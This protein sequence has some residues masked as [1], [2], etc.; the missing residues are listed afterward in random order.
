[1]TIE[2]FIQSHSKEENAFV[3]YKGKDYKI[4][5]LECQFYQK[6]KIGI[7][8]CYSMFETQ[9]RKEFHDWME[10]KI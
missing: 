1:M 7:F 10:S 2:Q 9:C 6:N 4:P 3:L 8:K 5:C